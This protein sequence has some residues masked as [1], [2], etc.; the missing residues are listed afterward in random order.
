METKKYRYVNFCNEIYE[1]VVFSSFSENLHVDIDIV[2]E[3]VA[4]RIDFIGNEEKFYIVD[5]N[6][7]KHIS[8]EAKF[9]TYN[10]REGLENV[11]ACAI[12]A[13]NPSSTLL[14]NILVKT[15]SEIPFKH[16]LNKE[17]AVVWIEE[18]KSQSRLSK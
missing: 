5:I 2:K 15:P 4:C 12:I 1:D 9:Y 14:A 18:L 8:S 11:L 3:I 16:F 17:S 6:N 13:T 7:L 10:S